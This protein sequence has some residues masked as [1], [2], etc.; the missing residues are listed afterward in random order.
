LTESL[1][2]KRS[3]F[4]KEGEFK[5]YL[6][7]VR[8]IGRYDPESRSWIVD[9]KKVLSLN[10]SELKRVL[11]DLSKYAQI[12]GS[13]VWKLRSKVII[14]GG[15]RIYAAPELRNDVIRVLSDLIEPVEEGY[16]L[17][18]I[19]GLNSAKERLKR[20]GLELIFEKPLVARLSRENGMLE[21]LLSTYDGEVL[22]KIKDA[23]TLTY[24]IERAI[25]SPEGE[26]EGS[27]IIE[28]KF[29]V[30][31]VFKLS[32]QVKIYTSVGLLD[33]VKA[34]LTDLGF[35][36]KVDITPRQAHKLSIEQKFELLPHQEEAYMAWARKK[37]GTIAIFTRGGKSFIA[38]KAIA[39]LKV[40]SI[41]FVTTRELVETWRIYLK[42]YLGISD[43]G[44]LGGGVKKLSMITIAIYNSAVKYC[45]E[46]IGKFELAIFDEAHHV[47]ATTFK[48]VAIKIDAL[49]RMAL[50]ATPR[51]RDGNEKLLYE[52][53]GDL[54]YSLGYEG[55][56]ALRIVAPIEV[57]ESIFVENE[58]EKLE[59]LVSVLKQY[60]WSRAIV[61][62]QRLST[63]QK[64]YE[65]LIRKGFK[66]TLITGKT[67]SAKRDLAFRL[68]SQG[69]YKIV[70]TTTVLDEGI[71]VPD[72]DMAIIYEGTGEGRQMIQRI[73]RV[74]GYKPGKTAKII[75][76]INISV[77]REKYAYLRRKWVKELYMVPGLKRHVEIEKTRRL[78]GEV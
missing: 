77:P 43:I 53:C 39:D 29:R 19:V 57:F 63:A 26:Y 31:K 12:D 3:R 46:L 69:Y 10:A 41:I 30:Y 67:P 6:A 52:L 61:F 44:I 51:R 54:I 76:I 9:P 4:L 50:S 5:R 68:F 28:R 71:T 48:D 13:A 73:G 49:Y 7:L 55:L 75:E 33:K 64:V 20:L 47:P 25:I 58:D 16:K 15:F 24:F 65:F 35:L 21:I 23:L 36:V 14:D 2:I 70:V 11:K 66:A 32:N 62:T 27:E 45:D 56:L 74:L 42:K 34:L 72:A 60:E 59:A 8:T 37:R 38:L 78:L 22:R 1:C 18:S 17:R 40:P